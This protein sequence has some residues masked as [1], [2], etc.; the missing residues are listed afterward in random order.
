MMAIMIMTWSV[1]CTNT[2]CGLLRTV[3]VPKWC[4]YFCPPTSSLQTLWLSWVFYYGDVSTTGFVQE[5]VLFTWD[6]QENIRLVHESLEHHLRG[7]V[8]RQRSQQVHHV[9]FCDQTVQGSEGEVLHQE[10]AYSGHPGQRQGMDLFD[11]WS[12]F[13]WLPVSRRLFW[14]Y[15]AILVCSSRSTT[16]FLPYWPSIWLVH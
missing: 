2:D 13:S 12:W 7:H 11:A 16:N 4:P 1:L 14:N 9:Y 10:Q 8:T 6:E 5:R 3:A 15:F